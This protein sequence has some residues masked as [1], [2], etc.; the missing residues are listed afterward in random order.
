MSQTESLA[1]IKTGLLQDRGNGNE[2]YND[3][4][5]LVFKDNTKFEKDRSGQT[6]VEIDGVKVGINSRGHSGVEFL[7]FNI[8][9]ELYEVY[10]ESLYDDTRPIKERRGRLICISSI[11]DFNNKDIDENTS[12]II[13]SAIIELNRRSN[14]DSDKKTFV[15]FS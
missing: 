11:K 7:I 5:I 2:F 10:T 15:E 3:N 12:S 4:F 13:K 14:I 1:R 9:N 8:N 6:Y